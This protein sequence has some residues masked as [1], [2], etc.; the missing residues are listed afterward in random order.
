MSRYLTRL[1]ER[2]LSQA[3]AV[4]ANTRLPFFGT[5]EP[6]PEVYAPAIEA[7][8]RPRTERDV[9]RPRVTP[10][11][12]P[13]RDASQPRTLP[14]PPPEPPASISPARDAAQAIRKA[15]ERGTPV[16]EPRVDEAPRRAINAASEVPLAPI[17][18]SVLEPAAPAPVAAAEAPL[19]GLGAVSPTIA[20]PR[21]AVRRT[22]EG[23]HA[24]DPPPPDV[25]IHIGRIELT[26]VSEP[27]APP[28]SSKPA[29]KP[30]SLDEY[31]QHRS[32]SSP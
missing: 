26:A 7:D 15:P 5:P 27:P 13:A 17:R 2:A 25:H 6:L 3:P 14:M 9:E 31:L 23:R 28:R 32:G 30:M 4:H 16:L 8:R 29:K 10:P 11:A 19:A 24:P 22:R 21:A 1:A 12:A 18:E 20:T